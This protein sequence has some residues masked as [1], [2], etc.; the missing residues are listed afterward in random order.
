[1]SKN[2]SEIAIVYETEDI[3]LEL[4]VLETVLE[5]VE[6]AT[7]KFPTWPNDPLHALH[8]LGEEF[9]ELVKE[10][11]QLVYEPNKTNIE[12]VK[13]EAIQTAAMALRFLFSL[14]K[15]EYEWN[16]CEQHNQD[17]SI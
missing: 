4:K 8:V 10:A 14:E 5:E 7:E 11:L 6:K 13:K 1:M 9:G 3:P 12:E 16:K 17:L 2:K 15:D